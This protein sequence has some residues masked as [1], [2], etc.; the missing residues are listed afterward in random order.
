M[1][2]LVEWGSLLPT[3]SIRT[4]ISFSTVAYLTIH[5]GPHEHLWRIIPLSNWSVTLV[6]ASPPFV[7]YPTHTQAYKDMYIYNIYNIYSMII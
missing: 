3:I 5:H 6:I 4:G 2:Q 1:L 7:A